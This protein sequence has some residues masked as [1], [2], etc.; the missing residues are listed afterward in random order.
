MLATPSSPSARKK[1]AD[2]ERE[3][4]IEAWNEQG[5]TDEVIRV[6]KDHC[7]I[8][9]TRRQYHETVVHDGL[10]GRFKS[11]PASCSALCLKVGGFAYGFP[12]ISRLT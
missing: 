7:A 5:E 1:T 8:A 10:F 2:P 3:T 9:R 4:A 12:L 6:P 11:L